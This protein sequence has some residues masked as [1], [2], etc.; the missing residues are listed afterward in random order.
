MAK[1]RPRGREGQPK[2]N[3]RAAKGRPGEA[4]GTTRE[5]QEKP[6]G[7]KPRQDAKMTQGIGFN[8]RQVALEAKSSAG[9]SHV[10]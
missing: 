5:G 2:G 7:A 4:K 8:A 10:L 1:G 9:P 6:R 3:Q